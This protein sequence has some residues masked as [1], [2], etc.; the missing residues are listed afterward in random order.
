MSHHPRDMLAAFA[1]GMQKLGETNA[2][3]VNAFMGLVGEN[4]KSGAIDAKT[5][6]LICVGIA[7]FARC[8]YCIVYHVHAA[9]EAG[10]TGKEIMEAGLVAVDFGGGPSMTYAATLLKDSI[11]EFANDFEARELTD[12]D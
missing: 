6:E 11:E 12:A 3:V 4:A 2:N 8:E 9:Y 1:D 10:A 5:K 7:V